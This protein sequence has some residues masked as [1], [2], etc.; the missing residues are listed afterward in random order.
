MAEVP[1]EKAHAWLQ[2]AK[3]DLQTARLIGDSAEV[4]LGGAVYHC[5][6]AAE[7][8]VKAFLVAHE[9]PFEKIHDIERL[10]TQAATLNPKF[11]QF[12]VAGAKLTPLGTAYRYPQEVGFVEPTHSEF[13]EALEYAQAIYDF[14]LSLLPNES[15]P[16]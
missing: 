14:V 16:V 7:K 12:A 13:D 15:H 6:Q 2:I 10:T 9:Q 8:A 1:A 5:Q 4:G 3:S 11:S